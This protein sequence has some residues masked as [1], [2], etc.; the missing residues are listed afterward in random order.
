VANERKPSLRRR[1]AR[2]EAERNKEMVFD[3]VRVTGRFGTNRF[4]ANAKL[5]PTGFGA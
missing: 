4:L 2:S 5:F 3:G 1:L